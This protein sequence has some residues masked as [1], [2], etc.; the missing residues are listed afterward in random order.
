[1]NNTIKVVIADD[2]VLFREGLQALLEKQNEIE[3]VGQAGNGLELEELIKIKQ[4]HV[5]FVDIQM[6][7]CNGVEATKMIKAINPDTC[8]IGLSMYL[9]QHQFS[10][11]MEAG[12]DGYIFKTTSRQ[13]LL[14]GVKIVL[15]GR[16]FFCRHTTLHLT[17]TGYFPEKDIN[18]QQKL[19]IRE[20][21]II[22]LICQ[23]K[24]S[25]EIAI[26]KGISCSTVENYRKSILRK[27][28][29]INIAGIVKYA[30]RTGLDSI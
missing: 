26:L 16:T 24:T 28:G 12:A 7:L 20:K 14:K 21:E 23:E 17:S 10:E 4:P 25:R 15:E 22:A 9:N 30:I 27:T 1:M 18:H 11:M 8:V 19:T 13:E 3:L 29:S 5:A 2:H 6:P